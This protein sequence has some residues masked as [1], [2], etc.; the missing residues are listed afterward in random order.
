MLVIRFKG[1]SVKLDH[2]VGSAGKHGIWSFHGSESSYV[3]D[4]ETILRPAP[5]CQDQA[6]A[7]AARWVIPLESLCQGSTSVSAARWVFRA[8]TLRQSEASPLP[9]RGRTCATAGRSR[10]PGGSRSAARRESAGGAPG[11]SPAARRRNRW[12]RPRPRLPYRRHLGGSLHLR[13]RREKRPVRRKPQR[14]AALHLLD[15]SGWHHR[16]R[17]EGRS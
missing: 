8:E 13:E 15:Q 4:M 16:L 10:R 1:W 12:R 3:P 17:C 6:T 14:P 9:R 11:G 5:L 2:Q 7:P